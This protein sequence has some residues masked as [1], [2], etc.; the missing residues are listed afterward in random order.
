MRKY[1]HTH[2]LGTFLRSRE[3]TTQAIGI[4][5]IRASE[6][7]LLPLVVL[8]GLEY[9]ASTPSPIPATTHRPPGH[10]TY[11]RHV[12]Q[13][14]SPPSLDEQQTAHS[15]LVPGWAWDQPPAD[16]KDQLDEITLKGVPHRP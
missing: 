14:Q 5:A 6:E 9:T 1:L 2:L 7:A 16:V 3:F 15:T 8:L 12:M 11:S 4:C 10:L 13:V